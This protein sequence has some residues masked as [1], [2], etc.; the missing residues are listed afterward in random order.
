[1]QTKLTLITS[2]M[3]AIV[4]LPAWSA[5]AADGSTVFERHCTHCHAAGMEY[6]GTHQLTLTRGEA[7]AV[8]EERDNL[9]AAYIKTIVRQGLRAMPP[10]KPTVISREELDQLANYLSPE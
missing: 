10:F 6:P 3:M 8:L 4:P 5:S 9:T 1:M 7:M 2:L